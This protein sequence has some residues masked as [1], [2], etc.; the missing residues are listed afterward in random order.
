MKIEIT[1]TPKYGARINGQFLSEKM[2]DT[3]IKQVRHARR[4]NVRNAD[5]EV[6][7]GIIRAAEASSGRKT[8]KDRQWGS[9]Y[10]A[11]FDVCAKLISER[12]SLTQE[13]IGWLV[14]SRHD[15][16]S[17]ALK[18]YMERYNDPAYPEYK[19]WREDL[20]KHLQM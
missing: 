8:F 13:Q 17:V 15:R 18:R 11:A 14:D 1:K 20:E 9:I 12:T 19:R 6:A 10:V 3:V 5:V 2:L 16:I 4:S 7:R